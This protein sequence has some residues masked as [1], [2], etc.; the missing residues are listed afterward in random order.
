MQ[1]NRQRRGV[2]WGV[3]VSLY[4]FMGPGMAATWPEKMRV[5]RRKKGESGM[6]PM[7]NLI[8]A[9][10]VQRMWSDSNCAC[11]IIY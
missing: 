8:K 10:K 1:W 9:E 7:L 4:G 11:A 3:F 6:N 2:G 5:K